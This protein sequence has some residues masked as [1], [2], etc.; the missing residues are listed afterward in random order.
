MILQTTSKQDTSASTDGQSRYRGSD[1]SK[2]DGGGASGRHSHSAGGNRGSSRAKVKQGP[3]AWC[4]KGILAFIEGHQRASSVILCA[5]TAACLVLLF[6]FTVFSGLG[7]S[8]DFIY[9]QF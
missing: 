6:W 8:A 1:A 3:L 5:L 7:S 9:N 2:R 4:V